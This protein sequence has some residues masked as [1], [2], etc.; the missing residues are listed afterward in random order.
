M[1]TPLDPRD[2]ERDDQARSDS[3]LADDLRKWVS[4]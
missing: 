1:T 4:S 2:L 3:E